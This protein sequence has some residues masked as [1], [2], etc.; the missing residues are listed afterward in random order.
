[1]TE[2]QTSFLDAIHKI[3]GDTPGEKYKKIA[4]LVSVV[5]KGVPVSHLIKNP[6]VPSLLGPYFKVEAARILN[7]R[8]MIADAL[9]SEDNSVIQKAL[10]IKSFFDG[11]DGEFTNPDYFSKHLIPHVSLNTRLEIIKNLSYHLRKPELAEEFFA[12]FHL[13]YGIDQAMPLLLAC[14]SEFTHKTLIEKNIVLSHKMMKLFYRKDPNLVIRHIKHARKNELL[15]T[16]NIL[17]LN[18]IDY[19]DIIVKFI[20][21]DIESF[22]E[23]VESY[24]GNNLNLKFSKNLGRLFMKIGLKY[25]LNKP[26]LYINMIPLEVIDVETMRLIFPNLLPNKKEHFDTNQLLYVLKY[27]PKSEKFMLLEKSYASRYNR[28]LLDDTDIMT[29]ELMLLLPDMERI[30]QAKIMMDKNSDTTYY[31]HSWRCYYKPCEVIPLIKDDIK[32]ASEIEKR[33]ALL[34]ELIYCCKVNKDSDMLLEVLK[35]FNERH[36]NERA[37]MFFRL[38]KM[39]QIYGDDLYSLRDEHWIVIDSIIRRMHVKGYIINHLAETYLEYLFKVLEVST[40]HKLTHELLPL[41]EE[42]LELMADCNLERHGQCW[43]IL[44][45]KSVFEKRSLNYFIDYV[46]QKIEDQSLSNKSWHEK[47]KNIVSQITEAIYDFNERHIKSKKHLDEKALSV[48]DYPRLM[49]IVLRLLNNEECKKHAA[50]CKMRNLLKHHDKELFET[51]VKNDIVKV[52]SDEV[53][54]GKA[55]Y[56]LKRDPNTIIMHWR[57]YLSMCKCWSGNKNVIRFIKTVRWHNGIAMKWREECEKGFTNEHSYLG[58]LGILLDGPSFVQIVSPFMPKQTT[59]PTDGQNARNDYL[60]TSKIPSVCNLVNPPPPLSII[61]H[62]FEGDYLS[63]GLIMSTNLCRRTGVSKVISFLTSLISKRVSVKKHAI[64]LYYMVATIDDS[65]QLLSSQWQTNTNHSIREILFQKIHELFL[66]EPTSETYCLLT[67][68]IDSLTEDDTQ[69]LNLLTNFNRVPN[70]Y[71]E[72]YLNKTFDTIGKKE[73]RVADNHISSMLSRISPS[74]CDILDQHF[75]MRIIKKYLFLR[76]VLHTALE[77]TINSFILSREELL[78]RRL[79][80]FIEMISEE[81]R[82]H[83]DEPCPKKLHY[84]AVNQVFHF[85]IEQ[86][87]NRY[88]SDKLNLRHIELLLGIFENTLEPKMDLTSYLYLICTKQQLLS[89]S[90]K[91]FGLRIAREINRLTK[92]FTPLIIHSMAKVMTEFI[93]PISKN[94]PKELLI[95]FIEGLTEENNVNNYFMAAQLFQVFDCSFHDTDTF[96]FLLNCEYPIVTCIMRQKMNTNTCYCKKK[97]P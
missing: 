91:D 46:S 74:I 77:L 92:E 39:L 10:H 7:N 49:K 1:M 88:N 41:A 84:F 3:P 62:F 60:L 5:K 20:K 63:D 69:Q 68:S 76:N 6:D 71:L 67:S 57:E 36:K 23:I 21:V 28:K 72:E 73:G 17:Q 16:R 54:S 9:K 48:S 66:N 19:A 58:I 83:W 43:N 34:S 75:C 29:P 15:K 24:D 53:A 51:F 86:L 38:M 85:F 96:R 25:L 64:R 8:Q 45:K 42:N 40:S 82:L 33:C 35:Y 70:E 18:L 4:E 80:F 59:L 97:L 78:E 90:A 32:K 12:R 47:E 31:T 56:L 52:E 14:R 37:E 55:L 87:C 61:D 50:I 13:L 30:K 44:K 65:C 95:P 27:F 26:K 22:V 94:Q 2:Q 89:I 79:I 81:I 93:D 11:S